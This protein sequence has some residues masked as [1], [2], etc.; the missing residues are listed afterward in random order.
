MRIG[1]ILSL[2]LL[3]AGSMN[4]QAGWV[5]WTNG[6]PLGEAASGVF[7]GGAGAYAG[8]VTAGLS[9]INDGGTPGVLGLDARLYPGSQL[10]S[11]FTA[12]YPVNPDG[13]FATLANSYNNNQDSY[14]ITLDFSGLANGF[15]PSG[16]LFAVLDLDILENYRNV[17]AFGPGNVQIT[18]TWLAALGGQA[19]LLDWYGVDGDQTGFVG[20]PTVSF[21]SGVYQFLGPNGNDNSALAGFLTTQDIRTL[22]LF[23]DKANNATS[24]DGGGGPGLAIG[25]FQEVPE[26]G[27]MAL[28]TTAGLAGLMLRRRQ[29]ARP[30]TLPR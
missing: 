7:G 6:T 5:I 21:S 24:I 8:T 13:S 1:A 16:S 28:F 18:S 19:A 23:F 29:S 17:T 3:A 26:P 14:T 25:T 10:T 30:L 22:T 15:L 27:T 11:S 20:G 9:N 4:L 12:N 2:L